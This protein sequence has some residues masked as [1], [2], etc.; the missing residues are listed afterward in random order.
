VRAPKDVV[1]ELPPD[2]KNNFE[3]CL[4]NVLSCE[5][6]GGGFIVTLE[7]LTGRTHQIRAQLSDLGAPI[8]GDEMY[9]GRSSAFFG[10][11]AA[12]LSFRCPETQ[13]NH[14]FK[15]PPDFLIHLK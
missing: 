15:S 8:A 9:G 5:T 11:H 10:L 12:Q 3:E 13:K 4:M 14:H 2:Q 7:L 6:R 1:R